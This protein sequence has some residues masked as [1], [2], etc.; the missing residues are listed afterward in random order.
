MRFVLVAASLVVAALS[1]LLSWFRPQGGEDDWSDDEAGKE[2]VRGANGTW[3]YVRD[4]AT[5][6]FLLN[7]PPFTTTFM[8]PP[9]WKAGAPA[10]HAASKGEIW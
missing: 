4:A 7:H 2:E 8:P 1:T 3:A 9:L 6:I 5:T 10:F